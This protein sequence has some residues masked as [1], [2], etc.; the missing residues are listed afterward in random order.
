MVKTDKKTRNYIISLPCDKM[1]NRSQENWTC[2]NELLTSDDKSKPN[3]T[4]LPFLYNNG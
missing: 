2:E 3:T 4:E 1:P